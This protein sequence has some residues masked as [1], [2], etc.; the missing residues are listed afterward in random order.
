M[1]REWQKEQILHLTSNPY[2]W[3]KKK[4]P[5]Q[6]IYISMIKD[7]KTINEKFWNEKLDWIGD[8]YSVLPK[9]YHL[10][11]ENQV[12]WKQKE[13]DQIWWIYLNTKTIPLTS[14]NIRKAL[15][16][17][18]DRKNVVS[19]IGQH[20]ILSP[21]PE[22]QLK[23]YAHWD[24]NKKLAQEFFAEGLKELNLTAETFPQLIFHY[25][26]IPGQEYLAKSIQSQIE[27]VLPIKIKIVRIEWNNLSRLLD[28][29]EYQLAGC[30][31]SAPYFY[32]RSHLE[33][34]RD[35]LHLYNSSQWENPQYEELLKKAQSS[36]DPQA[37]DELLKQAEQILV[38]EMPVIA[39]FRHVFKYRVN[40]KIKGISIA[41]N[42][43]ID[44]KLISI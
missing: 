22:T 44:L 43:D 6:D 39:I 41:Q 31:R 35:P 7:Y 8:P 13:V 2:Y 36:V 18:V 14:A 37:R 33:F 16:C 38:E 17:A 34:F 24:G 3:D 27:D 12:E 28:K 4:V 11:K 21:I 5:L 40:P 30:L 19:A 25:S 32:P 20:A 29:R 42:G 10:S 15:A 26:D 9:E 23:E 1:V